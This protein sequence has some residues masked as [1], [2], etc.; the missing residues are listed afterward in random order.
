MYSMYWYILGM[1]LSVFTVYV[2]NVILLAL[3][4]LIKLDIDRVL[5]TSQLFIIHVIF[6][7]FYRWMRGRWGS[8]RRSLFGTLGLRFSQ[9]QKRIFEELENQTFGRKQRAMANGRQKGQRPK[10][11]QDTYGNPCQSLDTTNFC[12]GKSYF[13]FTQ[14]PCKKVLKANFALQPLRASKLHFESA[15]IVD[16]SSL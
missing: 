2:R 7:I 16:L 15:R 4:L 14:F 8:R 12:K 3:Q 13:D 5:R 9:V 1:Y 10:F 11:C 6:S